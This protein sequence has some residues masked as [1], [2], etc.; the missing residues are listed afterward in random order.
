MTA[1]EELV[2]FGDHNE[3]LTPE[4]GRAPGWPF[5]PEKDQSIR[6]THTTELQVLKLET[7]LGKTGLAANGSLRYEKEGCPDK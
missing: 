2:H 1:G 3:T 5:S 7:F 4:Q 6:E